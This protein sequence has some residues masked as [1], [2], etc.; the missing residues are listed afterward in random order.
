MVAN[1]WLSWFNWVDAAT[2][3][4]DADAEAGDLVA[5]NLRER[6]GYKA[7]RTDGLSTGVTD[8]GITIDFGQV[9]AVEALAVMFPRTN[10]P[11]LYDE[12]ADFAATDTIRHRLSA[13]S[14]GAGELYDSGVAA[15]GVLAGYGYHVIRLPAA[16]NAR[17]WR[18]DL[19]AISRAALGYVD[20]TRI[21]A[22]PVWAPNVGFSFGDGY[23]WGSDSSVS[24][25]SRGVAEFVDNIE[26]IRTWSLALDG[27]S[28]SEREELLEFERRVT[29]GAQFLIARS[30]VAQG[31]GEMLA[32][33][34]QSLGM[35]SLAFAR[36]SKAFRLGESL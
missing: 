23:G 5:E 31:K 6:Q 22:G 29:T 34:Q 13:V 30:D 24:R 12:P 25:A 18:L 7:W 4:L 1:I 35:S 21:W 27:L 32:R 17:W 10:D 36:N 26:P 33:Q 15:S 28:D 8:A 9:R 16:V 20:V 19:D 3:T 2:A 14:A 11:T